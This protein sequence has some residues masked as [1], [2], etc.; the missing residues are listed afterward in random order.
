MALI[1]YS[2]Y[3]NIQ[4]ISF[5]DPYTVISFVSSQSKSSFLSQTKHK[6]FV[7]QNAPRCFFS[8]TPQRILCRK[9]VLPSRKIYTIK[10]I[11]QASTKLDR[12]RLRWHAHTSY[13]I[14]CDFR[15]RHFQRLIFCVLALKRHLVTYRVMSLNRCLFFL[16]IHSCMYGKKNPALSDS[17]HAL[18]RNMNL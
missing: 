2:Q 16:F 10:L 12:A 6:T 14:E 18:W 13:H 4:I 11:S 1:I 3:S 5:I 9:L 8:Y 15:S 17:W 7:S